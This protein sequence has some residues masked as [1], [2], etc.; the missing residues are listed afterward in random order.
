MRD[1]WLLAAFC[2]QPVDRFAVRYWQPAD[3]T[4]HVGYQG[5]WMK[6]P[7]S[8]N[9]YHLGTFLYPFAVT[10]VNGMS[11]WQENFSGIYRRLHR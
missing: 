1:Q 5:M 9:W 7:V 3:G 2:D 11:G 10:G 8:G 6:E 4:P